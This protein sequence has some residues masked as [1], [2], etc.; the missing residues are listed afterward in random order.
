VRHP[1]IALDRFLDAPRDIRIAAIA[2]CQHGLITVVQL[3][4]CGLDDA[5]VA[6]RVGEGRMHRV[7]RG[8]YARSGI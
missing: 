2:G 7:D 4:R 5:A 8:V 6:R 1:A 3:R